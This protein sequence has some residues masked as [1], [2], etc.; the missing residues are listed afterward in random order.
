M[1]M[2]SKVMSCRFGKGY[3]DYS[4]CRLMLHL[5]PSERVSEFAQQAVRREELRMLRAAD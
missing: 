4:G 3:A 5:T 2:S 1:G